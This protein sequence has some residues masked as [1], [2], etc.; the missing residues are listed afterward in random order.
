MALTSSLANEELIKV[1]LL[2]K[3]WAAFFDSAVTGTVSLAD[4]RA[5]FSF[6]LSP[7][8]KGLIMFSP[9]VKEGEEQPL[10][11]QVAVSFRVN[12]KPKRIV[13]LRSAT[14][15]PKLDDPEFDRL[16]VPWANDP[17]QGHYLRETLDFTWDAEKKLVTVI[18]DV[19][20]RQ[21]VWE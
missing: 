12:E 2:S 18:L 14:E 15:T 13:A 17:H 4:H 6:P 21:L 16:T 10:P 5:S 9:R 1:E 7:M 20:I 11:L 19:G 8:D 3:P